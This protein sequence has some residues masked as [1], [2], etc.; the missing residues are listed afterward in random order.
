MR[1]E[2]AQGPGKEL[3]IKNLSKYQS[4]NK[5]E[6]TLKLYIVQ[7]GDWE[8]E[9]NTLSQIFLSMDK[10]KDG[11][12]DLS[13]LKNVFSEINLKMDLNAFLEEVDFDNNKKVNFS[14]FLT[15]FYDFK[16]NVKKKELRS[17]FNLIDTDKS[18]TINKKELSQFL[19]LS[20]EDDL[21]LELFKL[22]DL[23]NDQTISFDEFVNAIDKNLV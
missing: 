12:L 11:E 23:N 18:G 19:S 20:E 2:R 7:S 6:Q 22:A 10:N 21:L 15:A 5:F 1:Q 9:K 13:E 3:L 8:N 4:Q 17:F 14:E 16:K